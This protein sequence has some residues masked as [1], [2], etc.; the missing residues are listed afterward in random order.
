MII[1]DYI[2][3]PSD[4]GAPLECP[5]SVG[6]LRPVESLPLRQ[7]QTQCRLSSLITTTDRVSD[8]ITA[9]TAPISS[10]FPSHVNK[11]LRYYSTTWVRTSPQIWNEQSTLFRLRTTVGLGLEG[12]DTQ[13]QLPTCLSW[14]LMLDGAK[15][16]PHREDPLCHTLSPW[17]GIFMSRKFI[18]LCRLQK[19]DSL[20]FSLYNQH[21]NSHC[22]QRLYYTLWPFDPR[23][24]WN[25]PWRLLT[26]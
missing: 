17:G 8:F 25:C 22:F 4:L 9:N 2:I 1:Y 19:H 24:G 13:S 10:V 15:W 23:S 6:G 3:I 5:G 12:A 14:R 7:T 21:H 20:Q 26:G 16:T 11:T 18:N